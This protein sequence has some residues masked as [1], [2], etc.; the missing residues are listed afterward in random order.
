MHHI[1][2][3]FLLKRSLSSEGIKGHKYDSAGDIIDIND[4]ENLV[5]DILRKEYTDIDQMKQDKMQLDSMVDKYKKDEPNADKEL[6][7]IKMLISQVD[8]KLQG[9]SIK[10]IGKARSNDE[11]Q[12]EEPVTNKKE[13]SNE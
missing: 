11:E 6:G 7:E 8:R 10:V 3:Q 13:Q 9:M 1:V 5:N 4:I 12:T 2:K